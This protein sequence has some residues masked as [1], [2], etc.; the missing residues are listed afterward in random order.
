M[1]ID[2]KLKQKCFHFMFYFV[3]DQGP[4]LNQYNH[5]SDR[6]KSH[7]FALSMFFNP[8]KKWGYQFYG[9]KS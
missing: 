6:M 4:S 2:F 7:R 9:D 1:S 8:L 3:F 5:L